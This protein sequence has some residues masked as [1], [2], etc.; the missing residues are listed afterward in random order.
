MRVY[1]DLNTPNINDAFAIGFEGVL[2]RTLAHHRLLA[3]GDTRK[4]V[5]DNLDYFRS[6]A[7][8]G[9]LSSILLKAFGHFHNLISTQLACF[10][11]EQ[12]VI[13]ECDPIAKLLN[14]CAMDVVRVAARF[15][16]ED[17]LEFALFGEDTMDNLYVELE[18]FRDELIR[19]V[20][21]EI[22]EALKSAIVIAANK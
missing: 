12:F 22:K 21:N 17:K 15:D 13:Y 6:K 9:H 16:E 4:R 7:Y 10:N 20:R 3:A 11:T 2:E 14:V 19:I 5:T 18:S 8:E 1:V